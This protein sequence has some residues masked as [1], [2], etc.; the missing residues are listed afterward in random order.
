[1]NLIIEMCEKK[2][3]KLFQTIR[4]HMQATEEKRVINWRPLYT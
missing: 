3:Y 1:M 2:L 4:V